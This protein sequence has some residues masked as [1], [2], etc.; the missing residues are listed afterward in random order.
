MNPR[1]IKTTCHIV[2]L[3]FWG[4]GFPV[5]TRLSALNALVNGFCGNAQ[6]YFF[7]VSFQRKGFGVIPPPPPPPPLKLI[8]FPS[9][10]LFPLTSL[11]GSSA[12]V[13]AVGHPCV[14]CE[15]V[16][17]GH[18]GYFNVGGLRRLDIPGQGVSCVAGFIARGGNTVAQQCDCE[19]LRSHVARARSSCRDALLRRQVPHRE[20]L[21]LQGS[22]RGRVSSLC[23]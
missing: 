8:S 23:V 10:Q 17:T 16:L 21:F 1:Q 4:G 11:L 3:V 14:L 5:N 12:S 6:P 15:R 13:A 19:G 2:T 9:S 7:H 22:Q 20:V 18:A